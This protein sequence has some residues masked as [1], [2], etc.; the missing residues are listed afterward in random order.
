MDPMILALVAS[1]CTG[2][3]ADEQCHVTA[4][5]IRKITPAGELKINR[6]LIEITPA[7]EIVINV[8]DGKAVWVEL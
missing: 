6:C 1:L 8:R 4:C 7:E 3:E 2:L 5:S